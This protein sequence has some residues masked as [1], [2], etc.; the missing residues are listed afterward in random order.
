MIRFL[1]V[2][3]FLV[4]TYSSVR[5][6]SCSS[7]D[8]RRT[9]GG[10]ALGDVRNQG[11]MGWCASFTAADLISFKQREKISGLGVA[12]HW[13]NR[14]VNPITW[15][16]RKI[17]GTVPI[18]ENA[19]SHTGFVT[20]SLRGR[21]QCLERDLPSD[22]NNANSLRRTL[23][24]IADVKKEYDRT[25]QCSAP[26]VQTVRSMFPRLTVPDIMSVLR[27]SALQDV[28]KNLMYRNCRHS[29]VSVDS[30]EL[31]LSKDWAELDRQLSR[32]NLVAFAYNGRVL[33]NAHSSDSKMNHTSSFVGRRMR[34]GKCEYLVR[35]SWGRSCNYYDRTYPCEQGN[36]WVPKENLIRSAGDF[37]YYP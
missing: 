21:F 14:S 11:A 27:N 35:N 28:H 15:M 16:R 25:E 34:A 30:T 10:R 36:V 1:F 31:S 7:V 33:Q 13:T 5:A 2:L 37:F 24:K 8:L 19:S 23:D 12:I 3:I 9:P 22:D 6:Q 4:S 29:Y 18:L 20:R 17:N 26:A 32:G